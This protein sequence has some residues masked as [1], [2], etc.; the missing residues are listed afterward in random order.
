MEGEEPPRGLRT[1]TGT[2]IETGRRGVTE[3]T[4]AEFFP[5]TSAKMEGTRDLELLIAT[6]YI[7]SA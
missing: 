6:W 1:L 2:E 3:G 4:E 7:T 5:L